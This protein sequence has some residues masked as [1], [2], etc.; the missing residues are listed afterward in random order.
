MRIDHPFY[1]SK[2]NNHISKKIFRPFKVYYYSQWI[3]QPNRPFIHNQK[4]KKN[5]FYFKHKQLMKYCRFSTDSRIENNID[6]SQLI[7]DQPSSDLSWYP[8]DLCTYCLDFLHF[9]L[10][11]EWWTS[12]I[13]LTFFFRIA[14][15]P[16]SIQQQRNMLRLKHLRPEL[17]ILQS[18]MKSITNSSLE[19]Q[20]KYS[21]AAKDLQRKH[22]VSLLAGLA[23]P[24]IQLPFFM[25]MFFALKN[26]P[27]KYPSIQDGGFLW[28]TNLAQVD[29]TYGLPLICSLT[30]LGLNEMTVR[31]QKNND[32]RTKNMNFVL[33]AFSFA[34]LPITASMPSIVSLYWT[35]SNIFSIMQSFLFQVPF[36]QRSFGITLLVQPDNQLTSTTNVSS[37]STMKLLRNRPNRKKNKDEKLF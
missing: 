15:L 34:M 19:E 29:T 18:E 1:I 7:I 10:G 12:V 37:D 30:F 20:R 5:E 22:G 26:L 11:Y 32:S 6:N 9:S 24:L 27:D 25:S 2:L 14:L 28:F 21:L 33:R 4:T 31:N 36:I 8:T 13:M 23:S 3:V 16:F 17:E 35:C